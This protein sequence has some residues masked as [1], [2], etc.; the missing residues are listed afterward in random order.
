MKREEEAEEGEGGGLGISIIHISYFIY[1]YICIQYGVLYLPVSGRAG[2][3][4][5]QG[6]G[7]SAKTKEKKRK[8][9]KKK[10]VKPVGTRRG[11]GREGKVPEAVSCCIGIA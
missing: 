9:R 6:G 11:E 5:G 4:A 1:Y 2:H 3:R 10:T 8:K 7:A